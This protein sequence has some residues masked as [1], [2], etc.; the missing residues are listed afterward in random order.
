M[1]QVHRIRSGGPMKKVIIGFVLLLAALFLA[2]FT[3]DLLVAGLFIPVILGA[4]R[5]FQLIDTVPQ[6]VWWI[7]L[8]IVSCTLFFTNASIPEIRLIKRKRK[9]YPSGRLEIISNLIDET[10]KGSTWSGQQLALLI[11]NLYRKNEGLDEITIHALPDHMDDEDLP[12]EIRTFICMQYETGKKKTES[13]IRL[14][15]ERAV[16]SMKGEKKDD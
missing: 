11:V 9:N 1:P 3:R 12:R 16:R 10:A 8:V 2:W 5:L 4:V 15:M 14:S 13:A 7:V 6:V